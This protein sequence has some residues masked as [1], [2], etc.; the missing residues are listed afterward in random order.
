[1]GM[2]RWLMAAVV[3]GVAIL[4]GAGPA[5]ARWEDAVGGRAGPNAELVMQGTGPGAGVA[6]AIAPPGFDPLNGYP[7]AFPPGS[8][9]SN[10]GFAGIINGRVPSTGA[11]LQMYCIDLLTPTRVGLGYTLGEWTD[12]NVPNTGFVARILNTYYPNSALPALAN[13][14]LRAA[15]VQ[16]SI[17]FFTDRYV[18]SPTDS[19]F[20]AV[21]DIVTAVLAAGPLTPPPQ[22][23]LSITPPSPAEGPIGTPLG[24]FVVTS[25]T[26]TATVAATPG[27]SM[28]ADAAGTTPVANNTSVASGTQLWL[29]SDI[30]GTG[31]VGA[32]TSAVVPTGNVFIYQPENPTNPSPPAA[33]KLILAQQG[34]FT[35]QASAQGA[36]F[37]TGSLIVEKAILGGAAGQQ[38]EIRITVVCNGVAQPEWVIPPGATGDV[39]QT[40]GPIRTPSACLITETVDGSSASVSVVVVGSGQTVVLPS[41]TD[42]NDTVTAELSDTYELVPGELVIRK[43][44]SGPN[45]GQQTAVVITIDCGQ[46]LQTT[47]TIPAGQ[48]D[49]FEQTFT[50]LPPGTECTVT[51]SGGDVPAPVASTRTAVP[52]GP[53][54]IPP[55]GS[56]EV[57]FENF[58][59]EQPTTTTTSTTTT[60][61]GSTTTTTP[62][63][64]TS[65]ARSTTTTDPDDTLPDTGS[66]F[67][68][69]GAAIALT[70]LGLGLVAYVAARFPARDE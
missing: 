47:V 23:T 65:V 29:L 4:F 15:A 57:A 17:W 5:A 3:V 12:A 20:A 44:F 7:A 67:T 27:V 49:P 25:S 50:G 37:D 21:N 55:G 11:I 16:A 13:N 34:T 35:A 33:Q 38:G 46:A 1:M 63:S 66:P 64:P 2:R 42:P 61:P 28:F 59:G 62:V 39:S 41:N 45:A 24:P 6:G 60:T 8:V 10:Q 54:T 69:P 31:G 70:L 52:D 19:L 68:G 53:V 56:V 36:Y 51:E 32:A 26:G 14:N 9:P 58:Y 30:V 48:T 40:F 22:P 18:V 43:S